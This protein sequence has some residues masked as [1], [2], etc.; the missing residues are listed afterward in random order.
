MYCPNCDL[1][2][3]NGA[4]CKNCGKFLDPSVKAPT[5]PKAVDDS[6]KN[7]VPEV[8]V[9]PDVPVAPDAP[10][11][12]AAA[13]VENAATPETPETEDSPVNEPTP[14]SATPEAPGAPV[15]PVTPPS[16]PRSAE[17]KSLNAFVQRLWDFKGTSTRK[18]FSYFL[19]TSFVA[20][21]LIITFSGLGSFSHVLAAVYLLMTASIVTRRLRDAGYK[22]WFWLLG[23][24]PLLGF[25]ALGVLLSMPTKT[26]PPRKYTSG[27]TLVTIAISLGVLVDYSI[28]A[29]ALAY[30]TR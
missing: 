30:I 3:Q 23:L 14:E 24:F 8:P 20:G 21:L 6:D 15:V 12:P 13:P 18:N 25:I 7:D 11:A 2:G 1:D 10:D 26:I 16:A 19:I 4:F 27:D 17:R 22:Q 5:A 28:V 29:S 9:G